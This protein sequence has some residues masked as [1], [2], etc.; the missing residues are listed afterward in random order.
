MLLLYFFIKIKKLI[1]K[2]I[3]FKIYKYSLHLLKIMIKFYPH[4]KF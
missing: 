1:S 4:I 3:Y 2:D